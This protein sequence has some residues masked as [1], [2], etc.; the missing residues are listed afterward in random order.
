[1]KGDNAKI[2]RLGWVPKRSIDDSLK[3]ILADWEKRI[4]D[5]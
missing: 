2:R 3:E 1:M 5:G 4:S